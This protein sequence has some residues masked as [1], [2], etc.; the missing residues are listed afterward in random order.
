M[1]YDLGEWHT[2]KTDASSF[3]NT[4]EPLLLHTFCITRRGCWVPFINLLISIR[5]EAADTEQKFHVLLTVTR[6]W[7]LQPVSHLPEICACTL[8]VKANMEFWGNFYIFHLSTDW[9][10]PIFQCLLIFPISLSIFWWCLYY[11]FLSIQVISMR[12]AL[13]THFLVLL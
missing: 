4:T 8:G 3:E 13:R 9:F 1:L 11:G 5:D 2:D 10:K 12:S 7:H 6:T